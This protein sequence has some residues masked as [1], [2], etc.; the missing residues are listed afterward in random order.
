MAYKG[1]LTCLRK[2][3]AWTLATACLDYLDSTAAANEGTPDLWQQASRSSPVTMGGGEE[4]HPLWAALKVLALSLLRI[5]DSASRSPSY[6][7]KE[8]D[9]L[10]N[11]SRSWMVKGLHHPH[12][13]VRMASTDVGI[14]L[15]LMVGPELLEG[16]LVPMG[17]K[18]AASMQSS[19]KNLIKCAVGLYET[20]KWNLGFASLGESS[21][22]RSGGGIGLLGR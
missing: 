17:A 21:S 12:S 6:D 9:T 8:L 1:T 4:A 22:A 16:S 14:V 13:L 7:K 2:L 10:I 19:K 3:N 5:R 11:K 20:G 18:M 15:F